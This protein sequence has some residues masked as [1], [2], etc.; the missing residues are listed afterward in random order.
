MPP[1]GKKGGSGSGGN[2]SK[3]AT[4]AAE[5]AAELAALEAALNETASERAAEAAVVRAD[6]T[7]DATK[8]ET[9]KKKYRVI[10]LTNGLECLLIQDAVD[11]DE[12]GGDDDDGD[13][14]GGGGGC[15][16]DDD[17]DGDDDDSRDGDDGSGSEGGNGGKGGGKDGRGKVGG[18]RAACAMAVGVGSWADPPEVQGLAHFLE[19]LLFMGTAKYPAENHYD[20]FLQK[21]GGSSNA[22]TECEYTVFH[23]DVFP[24]AF[25]EA[26][27]VFAQ[28]FVE[29]LFQTGSVGR[30]LKAI[31]SEFAQSRQND[32]TRLDELF[33]RSAA[34]LGHPYGN[35]TWGNTQ[36]LVDEPRAAGVDVHAAVRGLYA[37]YYTAAN[38][39]LCVCSTDSL[40]DLQAAVATAFAA[41]RT[42]AEPLPGGGGS[43]GGSGGGGGGSASVGGKKKKKKKK[44]G[45]GASDP[46]SAAMGGGGGAAAGGAGGKLLGLWPA[47][48]PV[49]FG[50]VGGKLAM[51][52]P[53]RH[54]NELRL[55]WPL[56]GEQL[57]RWRGKPSELVGHLVG[58]EGAGSIAS[59]LRRKGWATGVVA[60]VGATGVES[61]RCG[62]LFAVTVT[63]T[64]RGLARWPEV[65]GL[66][67]R[68]VGLLRGAGPLKWVFDE[69]AAVAGNQC[70]EIECFTPWFSS[71]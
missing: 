20:A 26:L 59:A 43:S 35:F 16:D 6:N 68:F 71:G 45:S 18:K 51:V 29:P 27:D 38:M 28:F 36:S 33:C 4:K 23:F 48:P 19:H 9:D 52:R 50:S 10:E 15:G 14:G 69:V 32:A 67:H 25:K 64:K 46:A 60:G 62:A 61:S 8:P 37:R 34:P 55:V 24:K 11:S 56:A 41:V 7:I 63:L 30:E 12:E 1:K 21:H 65:A 13:S 31:E 40:D 54:T 57:S 44:G 58:H 66:V 5:E 17:D 42:G 22:Y 49:D 70:V 39:R 2:A 53:V 3:A 47:P